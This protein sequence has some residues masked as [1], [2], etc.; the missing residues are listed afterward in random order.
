MPFIELIQENNTSNKLPSSFKGYADM[1]PH[2][3]SEHYHQ[4]ILNK[5]EARENLTMM[6]MWK[7]KMTTMWIVKIPM[8]IIINNYYFILNLL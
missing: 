3:L 4:I 1:N 8:M 7:M 5:I 6:N 2:I